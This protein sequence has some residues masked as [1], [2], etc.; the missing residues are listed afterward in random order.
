MLQ[1]MREKALTHE[2]DMSEE[3]QLPA[4]NR[5]LVILGTALIQLGVGTFYAWSI[6]NTPILKMFGV[7]V[8]DE[9]G[10]VAAVQPHLGSVSL[11]FSTGSL[12]LALSTIVV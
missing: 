12:L 11:I 5:W 7:L 4:Y 8:L 1:Q 3:T 9:Q 10:N 2:G 6:F